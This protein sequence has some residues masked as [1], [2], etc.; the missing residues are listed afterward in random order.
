M[1]FLHKLKPKHRSELSGMRHPRAYEFSKAKVLWQAELLAPCQHSAASSNHSG[2][3]TV[4]REK[5][6]SVPGRESGEGQNRGGKNEEGMKHFC[7][8]W[9]KNDDQKDSP[10]TNPGSPPVKKKRRKKPRENTFVKKTSDFSSQN[11]TNNCFA[12]HPFL[13][14]ESS[15]LLYLMEFYSTHPLGPGSATASSHRSC[16]RL[17]LSKGCTTQLPCPGMQVSIPIFGQTKAPPSPG[18][19]LAC[20]VFLGN[21]S[22]L[23][24]PTLEVK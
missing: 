10:W 12:D 14:R 20:T 9:Q 24:P 6:G 5:K 3:K 4:G 22:G 7:E 23:W 1:H 13:M 8:W 17:R 2:S 16:P 21:D 19:S 15:M 18:P 11:Q